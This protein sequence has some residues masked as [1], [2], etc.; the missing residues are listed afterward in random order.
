MGPVQRWQA[1]EERVASLNPPFWGRLLFNT[2]SPPEDPVPPLQALVDPLPGADVPTLAGVPAARVSLHLF[3]VFLFFFH[4]SWRLT[5]PRDDPDNIYVP[6]LCIQ[7]VVTWCREQ[8]LHALCAW[9]DHDSSNIDYFSVKVSG[10]FASWLR[11][12]S[13]TPVARPTDEQMVDHQIP[14]VRNAI[15]AATTQVDVNTKQLAEL[16][17]KQREAKK[18][19]KE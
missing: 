1:F 7:P 5:T 4:L 10:M 6:F 16:E 17:Q 3:S 13:T 8:A 9:R 2:D 11:Q 18:R 19:R 14:L 15:Q 12:H